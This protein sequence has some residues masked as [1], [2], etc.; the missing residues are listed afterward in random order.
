MDEGIKR[1]FLSR[2]GSSAVHLSTIMEV[3][4]SR[5]EGTAGKGTKK[6][7]SGNI[8]CILL[9][10]VDADYSWGGESIQFDSWVDE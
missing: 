2:L 6:Q 8:I 10:S 4:F 9:K 7:R 3:A 5:W 1:F